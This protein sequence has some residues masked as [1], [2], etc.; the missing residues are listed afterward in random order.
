M[1]I[2]RLLVLALCSCVDTKITPLLH[3]PH[4]R[5]YQVPVVPD[6]ALHSPNP[7]ECPNTR[8]DPPLTAGLSHFRYG[9][10]AP[11]GYGPCPRRRH[12][13]CEDTDDEA[14]PST[15]LSRNHR[16]RTDAI[17]QVL[18][19]PDWQGFSM[20][21][22][23]EHANAEAAKA[24]MRTPTEV[25]LD[26]Q[27]NRLSPLPQSQNSVCRSVVMIHAEIEGCVAG[28]MVQQS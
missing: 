5:V 9:S 17:T 16:G 21:E 19:H 11:A 23:R 25:L 14:R 6:T 3:E 28:L 15:P 24:A 20:E 1:H 7:L 26:L 27:V 13:G 22:A 18:E 4:G 2:F 8:N 10:S 12:N